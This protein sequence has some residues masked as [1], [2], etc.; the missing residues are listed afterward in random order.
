[1]ELAISDIRERRR[2]LAHI[3]W[4][5]AIALIAFVVF[6][7]TFWP[8]ILRLP[9]S[10]SSAI[11]IVL[12][13]AGLVGT[14]V[15]FYIAVRQILGAQRAS[16]AAR[17]A[18]EAA[19]SRVAAFDMITEVSRATSAI[20]SAQAHIRAGNW[21]EVVNSYSEARISLVKIAELP[22]DLAQPHK[23]HVGQIADNLERMNKRV[24]QNISKAAYTIDKMKALNSNS[25][26]EVALV[27]ISA[28][29][30]RTA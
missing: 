2:E 7:A 24:A 16:E 25:D 30:D 10:T 12:S 19:R 28:K 4:T 20:R 18:S 13:V 17:V 22:S 1:M 29:L 21:D 11:G 9:S 8:I 6:T 27:R 23:D 3:A 15:G 14:A 5:V 26:Y